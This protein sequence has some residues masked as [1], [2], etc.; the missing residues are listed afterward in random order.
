M[1]GGLRLPEPIP[2]ADIRR[3]GER[4]G[5]DGEALEDFIESLTLIDDAFVEITTKAEAARIA[6]MAKKNARK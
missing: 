3:E 4:R 2:R 5:H 1:G 6:A